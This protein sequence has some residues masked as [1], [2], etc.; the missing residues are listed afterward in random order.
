[1]KN[2]GT[3]FVLDMSTPGKGKVQLSVNLEKNVENQ[4]ADNMN[5]LYR[6][7]NIPKNKNL[8]D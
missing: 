8:L 4:N 1:M 6:Y 5:I 3:N 2:A 7:L